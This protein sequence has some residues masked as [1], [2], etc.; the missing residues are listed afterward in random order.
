M[1]SFP[2]NTV[3]YESLKHNKFRLIIDPTFFVLCKD[4]RSRQRCV[5]GSLDIHPLPPWTKLLRHSTSFTPS[6]AL[7]LRIP[8]KS[9]EN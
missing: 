1:K 4:A 8:L 6:F 3:F 9:F 2:K 5:S 7:T